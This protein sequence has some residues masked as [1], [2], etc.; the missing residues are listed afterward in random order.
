MGLLKRHGVGRLA[1]VRTLPGSRRLPH[2]AKAV[3]EAELPQRGVAYLHLPGLGGLRKPRPDSPNLG[4]R[5]ASFRNYAE[6]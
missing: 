3:L 5:N 1:D 4:W 6:E 2:F